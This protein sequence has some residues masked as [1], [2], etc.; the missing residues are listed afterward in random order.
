MVIFAHT[1]V[2]SMEKVRRTEI[3]RK[4]F[5]ADSQQ[6]AL[7]LRSSKYFNNTDGVTDSPLPS[8]KDLRP[9]LC[10]SVL[11]D[12]DTVAKEECLV[13]SYNGYY[14]LST[15]CVPGTYSKCMYQLFVSSQQPNEIVSIIS[16]ILQ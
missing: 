16:L 8:P 6:P 14:L 13:L 3:S 12:E 9:V 11:L 10:Q 15:S 1:F 7:A 4:H 5:R 2:R